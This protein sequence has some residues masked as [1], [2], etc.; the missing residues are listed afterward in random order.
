MRTLRGVDG[1]GCLVITKYLII[2]RVGSQTEQGLRVELCR[3]CRELCTRL[4]S[5]QSQAS[6][7]RDTLQT[8]SCSENE[9]PLRKGVIHFVLSLESHLD[10][11]D[12]DLNS[13]I[14][15]RTSPSARCV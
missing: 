2:T 10:M 3:V 7:L 6:V 15:Q 12:G 13:R 8:R 9:A 1:T 5:K 4:S 11:G 14:L